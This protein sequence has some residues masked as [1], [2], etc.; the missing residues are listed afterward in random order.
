MSVVDWLGTFNDSGWETLTASVM[1]H[2]TLHADKKNGREHRP[3]GKPR[4]VR[5]AP[6]SQ[7]LGTKGSSPWRCTMWMRTS[8][9]ATPLPR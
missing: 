7:G 9:H 8:V 6:G 3:T 5:V 1:I 4:D 2:S